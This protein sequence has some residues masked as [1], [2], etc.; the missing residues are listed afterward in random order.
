MRSRRPLTSR[1]VSNEGTG[2]GPPAKKFASYLSNLTSNCFLADI[3]PSSC[4]PLWLV[5]GR[6]ANAVAKLK[7]TLTGRSKS[8]VEHLFGYVSAS[9]SFIV[10]ELKDELRDLLVSYWESAR[11]DEE[12][13]TQI[14]MGQPKWYGIVNGC[15]FHSAVSE[16]QAEDPSEWGEFM[17]KVNVLQ[18]TPSVSDLRRL[19]RIVNERNKPTY[20]FDVTIFDLLHGLRM[21]Y[22]ILVKERR[23]ESQ[24]SSNIINTRDV[25]QAYDGGD[26]SKNT[27]IRQAAGIAIK[28]HPRTIDAIGEVVNTSCADVIVKSKDLNILSLQTEEDVMAHEDCR[29]FK[30]FVCFGSLRSAK[31]FLKAVSTNDAEAQVNTIHRIR[32]FCELNSYRAVQAK[33]VADQFE[34]AKQALKEERKFLNRIGE[35]KWPDH[36]TTAQENLLR[37]TLC[38]KELTLN[39]GNDADVLPSVWRCFKSLYPAKAKAVDEGFTN[40][41]TVENSGQ[42]GELPE[43]ENP[44]DETTEGPTPDG[45]EPL[46]C[47]DKGSQP[48]TPEQEEEIRL[49]KMQEEADSNLCEL[50]IVTH[51]MPLSQFTSM[52]WATTS[53]K[54]DLVFSCIT[55]VEDEELINQLPGFSKLVLNTGSYIFLI[56]TVHQFVHLSNCFRSEGFKVSDHPFD[57]VYDVSTIQRRNT[58]D[59][60][61]RHSDIALICRSPGEH[62][63]GFH[64]FRSTACESDSDVSEESDNTICRAHFASFLNVSACRKKLKRPRSSSPIFSWERNHDVISRIVQTFCPF[65]GL[66]IDPHPGPLSSALACLKTRR[67]CISITPEY[68]DI[69]FAQ[70]RLRIHASDAATMEEL[71]IYSRVLDPGLIPPGNI[72]ARYQNRERPL[73]GNGQ[74][75]SDC[76]PSDSGDVQQCATVDETE[77]RISASPIKRLRPND[78]DGTT[79]S[80]IEVSAAHALLGMNFEK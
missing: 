49:A 33:V 22:D 71:D 5:R 11:P 13:V 74:V 57:I 32:H 68:D 34:L 42:G 55:N 10:I 28:L 38:D 48:L 79:E 41:P 23:K 53:R 40:D 9:P 61:Q 66:V 12:D 65:E 29:L 44:H 17:W 1:S 2:I 31:A 54:A 46:G 8:P 3:K 72:Q 6:Q 39:N 25:A 16:L 59:F 15:Q 35:N 52:Q 30:S 62:P 36:M 45:A 43:A 73:E 51:K 67:K 4:V 21:E 14:I 7:C 70:G 27:S 24:R 69:K 60:P 77:E 80:N 76:Q 37:T 58:A 18:H 50:G 20:S 56:T 26:H 64:P 63:T 47:N 75:T 19:A 78:L